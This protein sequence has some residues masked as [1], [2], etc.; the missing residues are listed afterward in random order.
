[1]L[2]ALLLAAWLTCGPTTPP[3]PAALA[4]VIAGEAGVCDLRARV[5]VAHIAATRCAQDI[6]GGWHG[7]ADPAAI[8]TLVAQH[9]RELTDPAGGATLLFSLQDLAQPA[10]QELLRA[11]FVETARFACA[12]GLGLSAWRKE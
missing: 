11:G 7:D 1:M 9:Y 12:G 2:T 8:D 10:V 5:A 4:R 6:R 3:E